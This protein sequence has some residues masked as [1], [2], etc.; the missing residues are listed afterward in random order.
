MA[1]FLNVMPSRNPRLPPVGISGHTRR[2]YI[3]A[4]EVIWDYRP[5]GRVLARVGKGSESR[6]R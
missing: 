6:T 2:Y 4:E 1:A 5:T 3:A